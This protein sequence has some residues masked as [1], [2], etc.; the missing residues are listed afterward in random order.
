MSQVGL[1]FRLG[2]R[3]TYM[4]TKLIEDE[5]RYTKYLQY[6]RIKRG[7]SSKFRKIYT[8]FRK[9]YMEFR[10]IYMGTLIYP[11]FF[12]KYAEN[13]GIHHEKPTIEPKRGENDNGEAEIDDPMS[14]NQNKKRKSLGKWGEVQ[15]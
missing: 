14:S 12:R 2:I 7:L 9:I 5:Q 8:E 11:R 6:I 3:E 1:E 15:I 10:K 13:K 4:G